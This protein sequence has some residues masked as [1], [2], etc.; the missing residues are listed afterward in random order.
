[1]SDWSEIDFDARDEHASGWAFPEDAA[2]LE[3][4]HGRPFSYSQYAVHSACGERYRRDYLER[5]PR[6]T[7]SVITQGGMVHSVVEDTLQKYL[8]DNYAL[9]PREFW[10]DNA[11]QKFAEVKQRIDFWDE[12]HG[13][14]ADAAGAFEDETRNLLDVYLTTRMPELR[15]RMIE[16]QAIGVLNGRVPVV[17]YIDI[18]DRVPEDESLGGGGLSD[19]RIQPTD[20][21]RDLKV[22]KAN[23]HWTK[24]VNSAQLSLYSY[25]TGTPRVGFDIVTRTKK[26]KVYAHP[27]DVPGGFL[28]RE[29][30]ET[31]HAIDIM[32]H[33]A[34][35][36]AQGIFP[37]ADPDSWACN[38]KYCP[39]F[40]RCRGRVPMI[41]I[42]AG[43]Q[44]E[45]PSLKDAS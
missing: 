31:Q 19:D 28:V 12:A 36:I 43:T 27:V 39:Y 6:P 38:P 22:T 7:G 2:L 15:P 42:P 41:S 1:M 3:L 14:H 24:T 20:V 34:E 11:S 16:H 37:K 10:Q 32:V 8:D 33:R 29:A 9:P 23:Y 25:L 5:E 4:P 44:S 40:T 13:A 35:M 45:D 17:A 30:Q 18:V 26:P 21:I